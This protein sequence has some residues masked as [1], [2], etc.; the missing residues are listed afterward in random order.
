[1][2]RAPSGISSPGLPVRIAGAVE[3]LVARA[4][5]LA[6]LRQRGSRRDD[7]LADERVLA[8]EL[9][10]V[11]VERVGL[12]ENRIRDRDLAEVVQLAG[13]AEEV[14][15]LD[16][17]SEPLADARGEITDAV[18]MVVKL[19]LALVQSLEERIGG[20]AAGGAPAAR[21]ARIEQLIR[22]A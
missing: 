10:L 3:S 5:E 14:E 17:E 7:P 19:G 6:D 13:L 9:P 20:L 18:Q 8:D 21:L 16:G 4:N 12:G 22:G 11:G 2:I 15:L 1:M